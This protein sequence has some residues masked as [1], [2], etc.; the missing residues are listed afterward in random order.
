MGGGN[1][2]GSSGRFSRPSVQNRNKN[3]VTMF[4][5]TLS[6][7]YVIFT[8]LSDFKVLWCACLGVCVHCG[9]CVC[10]GVGVCVEMLV[11]FEM[12]ACCV[13]YG[14]VLLCVCWG[15]CVVVC[16]FLRCVC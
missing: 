9:V 15:V 16:V 6:F 1:F 12:C 13:C 5:F 11:C 2:D 7:S 8:P 14:T 3:G 10:C 4:R